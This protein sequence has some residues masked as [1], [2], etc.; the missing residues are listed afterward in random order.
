MAI[1]NPTTNDISF[2]GLVELIHAIED[3]T[4]TSLF[5]YTKRAT[6][7]SRV[8]IEQS[9][10]HE[11]II[12]DLM[13]SIMNLYAGL[14]MTSLNMN[15]YITN[16]KKVRDLMSIVSTESYDITTSKELLRKYVTGD[17]CNYLS[18][19]TMIEITRSDGS[20]FLENNDP[21]G[22]GGYAGG[23][24]MTPPKDV[25]FP[26]GRIIEVK[27]AGMGE[28][29]GQITINL[30]LQLHPQFIPSEVAAQFVALNFTPTV[31]QR[32]MQMSAGEL[33]F[34][35]DFLMGQ[36]LRKKRRKALRKDSTGIL[37]DMIER[38]ENNLANAWL[39]YTFVTP[40]KQNIANTILIFEKAKFDKAC[41][42]AGLRWKDA[43]SRQKFFDK[44]FSMMLC[45]VDPMF[46][47]IEIYYH[48]LPTFSVLTFDQ[49]KKSSKIDGLDILTVMKNYS[50]NTAPKF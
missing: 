16:S 35:S 3:H 32:Y 39:K 7:N 30:L 13:S 40:E 49:V 24:V 29:K 44:T 50:Q 10:A 5:Q 9:I 21:S 18:P 38:Q 20:K 17:M 15:Q 19:A 42:N 48:G 22:T 26:S 11:S 1:L 46:N 14:I 41:S 8:F 28:G 36:D 31:K 12:A 34:F 23:S 43:N 33:S 37:S 6:I 25:N 2:G 47:R 27:F 4:S 45:T